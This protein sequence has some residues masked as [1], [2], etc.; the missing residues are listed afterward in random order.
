MSE[1]LL[2]ELRTFIGALER[3]EAAAVYHVPDEI[4]KNIKR[5]KSL[6]TMLHDIFLQVAGFGRFQ[7]APVFRREFGIDAELM[8]RFRQWAPYSKER[9]EDALHDAIDR[10]DIRAGNQGVFFK[11]TPTREEGQEALGLLKDI[12][13]AAVAVYCHTGAPG[14][15]LY[16]TV[17][18]RLLRFH[19]LPN[20]YPEGNAF[21]Y[22]KLI[23][24]DRLASISGSDDVTEA[25]KAYVRNWYRQSSH[26]FLE[27][28]NEYFSYEE[29]K[30]FLYVLT[31][32]QIER[33]KESYV[34]HVEAEFEDVKRK[35]DLHRAR[36]LEAM[37]ETALT[38]KPTS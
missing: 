36:K 12:S 27:D 34:H 32:E 3:K 10:A 20:T 14:A 38:W 33:L 5:S 6:E 4:I 29:V 18:D 7:L 30:N 15:D 11:G 21:H 24:E 2:T 8:D 19:A 13:H 25:L 31:E 37:L 35:S 22:R 9:F 16:V 1:T 17:L 23:A 26:A 28:K